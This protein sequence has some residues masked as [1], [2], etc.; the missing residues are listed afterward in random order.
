MSQKHFD[1]SI[2]MVPRVIFIA[3]IFYLVGCAERDALEQAGHFETFDEGEGE[4]PGE[5][6]PNAE[7]SDENIASALSTEFILDPA[8]PYNQ[9]DIDVSD[10]IVT[11]KGEM[12]HLLAKQ[13]A[14]RL[15]KTVKGVRSVIDKLEVAPASAVPDAELAD[16]IDKAL[17]RDPATDAY[18]L[19]VSVRDGIAT[20]TGKVQSI[21]EKQLAENVAAGVVG[22]RSINN[23]IN[24]S[25]EEDRPDSEIKPE[26]EASLRF[27]TH[28]DHALVRVAVDNGSVTLTGTVGSAAEKL[29]ATNIAS[30][31]GGVVFVDNSRL[32]VEKWARD[33]MLRGDKY[34]IKDESVIEQALRDTFKR[35]PRLNHFEIAPVIE[36]GIVVLQGM[37]DN[38]KAKRAAAR[39]AR[40]TV[41]VHWV[42]NH[43][44]VRPTEEIKDKEIARAVEQALEIA[45]DVSRHDVSVMV[46]NRRVYLSVGVDSQFE[47]ARIDDIVSKTRGV[48][49]IHNNLEVEDVNSVYTYSPY[50]DDR[51]PIDYKYRSTRNGAYANDPQIRHEI[52]HN[53]SWNPFLNSEDIRIVVVKSVAT[54]YGEAGSFAEWRAAAEAAYKGGAVDVNNK[55]SI[56]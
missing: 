3:L 4:I 36:D 10:G 30:S 33:P 47:K 23:L 37:E 44:Q 5:G 14:A 21:S 17:F 34:V 6:I 39:D 11:L 15:A 40:N 24:I 38:L 48:A 1:K 41:G 26:I 54:L 28:I 46:V 27:D 51:D 18:E 16:R 43:I 7:L 13:R 25:P 45:L 22:V 19:V 29:W 42:K 35:D 20:L 12:S 32:K 9:L 55:L 53:I 49:A 56:E 2:T 31:V 52:K 50:V 8:I